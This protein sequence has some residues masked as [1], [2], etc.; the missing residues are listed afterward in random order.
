[1][2]CDS[3]ER[4]TDVSVGKRKGEKQTNRQELNIPHGLLAQN[5]L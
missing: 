2:T 1:M 3:A 4:S 5:Y